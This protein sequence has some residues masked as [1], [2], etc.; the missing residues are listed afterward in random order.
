MLNLSERQARPFPLRGHYQASHRGWDML[1]PWLVGTI[2]TCWLYFGRSIL[3]PIILAILLSFLLAPVVAI[4]RRSGLPRT[5]SVIFAVLIA[6]CG[7]GVTGA[8]IVSQASTLSQDAPAYAERI[9]EKAARVRADV[10][11]KFG[12]LTRE[13]PSGGS[14]HRAAERARQQGERDLSAGTDAEVIP[15]EVRDPPLTAFQEIQTIVVPALAPLETVLIV[16][17]VTIFVLFQKD[18][19]RD[20]LIR[21]MGSSD[22]HRSTIALDDGATRLSRY[23]LSQFFVNCGFGIIIWCGLFVLG[24]PSPGLW[25]ILAAL[26]RFVPYVGSIVAAAGPIAIAAAVDPGWSLATYVAL[27][28]LIVEPIIGYALEPMIYGRSTGLSPVSVVVA[29]LFW[30]WIWGPIGLV[31]SM[32]LTLMLVVL[33]RHVPAFA[34]FDI[35][36]G[37]RPA[38]SPAETFYQRALGGHADE[39]VEQAEVLLETRSLSTYYEEVVLPGLRLAAADVDRGAVER[40]AMRAIC[41][42]AKE[43][44][45]MLADHIDIDAHVA[46][47]DVATGPGNL[48]QGEVI[49]FPGAGPLDAAIAMMGAQLLRREGYTVREQSRDR[50]RGEGGETFDPGDA[51]IICILGLFDPRAASRMKRVAAALENRFASSRVIIGVARN[52]E[53]AIG[54]ED[55]DTALPR[56]FSD[57][58]HAIQL[59][60]LEL[61]S[62]AGTCD[63]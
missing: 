38:L 53:P 14:G 11:G 15:V 61:A 32:P 12:F 42:A 5:P 36:L 51:E 37:D 55:I 45:A 34:F 19:L 26:L 29:A 59:A 27:L 49:C 20:R 31:L 35:M 43:T 40:S 52:V 60:R 22:L 25:G 63:S 56:T 10:Q 28:F 21:L 9:A 3:I 62:G 8:V 39:A 47:P 30:T 57:V 16:V 24:V 54:I 23:F 17:I 50:L 33:G 44:L 13:T 18:D 1:A 6:L 58:T 46:A 2:V 48:E 4:I 7:I 41:D